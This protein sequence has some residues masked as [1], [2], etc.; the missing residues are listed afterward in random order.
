M[1]PHSFLGEARRPAVAHD[2]RAGGNGRN[3]TRISRRI[4]QTKV[5]HPGQRILRMAEVAKRSKTTLLYYSKGQSTHGTCR[6][7]GIHDRTSEYRNHYYAGCRGDQGHPRQ[8]ACHGRDERLATM[9]RAHPANCGRIQASILSAGARLASRVS[10]EHARQQRAQRRSQLDRTN[11]VTAGSQ[12][13]EAIFRKIP[14]LLRRRIFF[15]TLGLLCF[16]RTLSMDGRLRP[17]ERDRAAT[18]HTNGTTYQ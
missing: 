17:H 16:G 9:A 8:N 12:H 2:Q 7:L 14:K 1:G 6:D 3:K 5:H 13:R 15:V 11:Q 4:R 18:Q 10:G